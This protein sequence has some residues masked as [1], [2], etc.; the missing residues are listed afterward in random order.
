MVGVS[1]RTLR[2]KLFTNEMEISNNKMISIFENC[3][4]KRS[5]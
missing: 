2:K 5:T 1:G 4:I 3:L